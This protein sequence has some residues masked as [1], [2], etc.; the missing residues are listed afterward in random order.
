MIELYLIKTLQNFF[1]QVVN[2]GVSKNEVVARH[3][4]AVFLAPTFASALA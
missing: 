1:S 4:C 2:S 3:F